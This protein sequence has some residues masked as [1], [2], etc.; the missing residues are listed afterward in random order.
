MA[1]DTLLVLKTAFDEASY[2]QNIRNLREWQGLI[3]QQITMSVAFTDDTIAAGVTQ[4]MKRA[5]S[6]G[7]IQARFTTPYDCGLLAMSLWSDT[8]LGAGDADFQLRS[9]G[10]VVSAYDPM[11]WSAGTTASLQY[12]PGVGFISAGADLDVAVTTS[13]GFSATGAAI[14]VDLLLVK[15]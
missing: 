12:P 8:S 2:R 4:Q 7:T 15:F 1:G 3:S 13:G 9:G 14:V 6:G 10:V 5:L 11:N